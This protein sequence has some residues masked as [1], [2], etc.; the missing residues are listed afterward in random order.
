MKLLIPLT[1]GNVQERVDHSVKLGQM[2]LN[3]KA[4]EETS[5]RG[6]SCNRGNN[7][8]GRVI[9]G[10]NQS[11]APRDCCFRKRQIYVKPVM[12]PDETL[13]S[14]Q[15]L[16][17][18]CFFRFQRFKIRNHTARH[19]IDIFGVTPRMYYIFFETHGRRKCITIGKRSQGYIFENVLGT[20]ESLFRKHLK[21]SGFIIPKLYCVHE[22]ISKSK[23]QNRRVEIT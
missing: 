23:K 8:K 3:W 16:V 15:S 14:A 5:L 18:L 7:Q 4:R 20:K 17:I 12:Q 9:V 10:R 2:L 19:P 1:M 11:Q 6:R 21:M 22:T 13:V